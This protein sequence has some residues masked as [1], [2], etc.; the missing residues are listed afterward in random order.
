MAQL[1]PPLVNAPAWHA[2]QLHVHGWSNH[3]AQQQPQSMQHYMAWAAQAGLDAVWWTDHN[4]LFT[5]DRDFRLD[6]EQG[7]VTESLDI[8]LPY[9]TTPPYDQQWYAAW[10]AATYS[11]TIQPAASLH[12][13]WLRMTATADGDDNLGRFQYRLQSYLRTPVS[14]H[15][16]VRPLA[17]D[18]VLEFDARLCGDSGSDAY[19]EVRVDLSWHYNGAP[20]QQAIVYRLAPADHPAEVVSVGNRVTVTV[21][22]TDTHLSL[23]LLPTAALL[24]DGADNA[25]QDL[26]LAV[27]ARRQATA[28]LEVSKVRL[29]SR[30][31][32]AAHNFA[33]YRQTAQLYSDRYSV[34]SFVVWEQNAGRQHF[35]PFLPTDSNLIP[36][37]DDVAGHALVPMIHA[38]GGAVSLNHPFGASYPP[39]LSEAQQEERLRSTS[40]ELLAVRAWGV[41]AIEIYPRR[42]GVDL[43]RHLKLWDLLAAN[44]VPLCGVMSSDQHGGPMDWYQASMVTWIEAPVPEQDL[45]LSGL[46]RCRVFFG[47]L[48]RFD[49]VFDLRLGNAAMGQTAHLPRGHALLQVLIDPLPADAVVKLVHVARQPGPELVYLIDHQ[50]IDVTQPIRI[51]VNRPGFVRVELWSARGEPMAFSNRIMIA[52]IDTSNRLQYLP[53]FLVDVTRP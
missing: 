7:E 27:A 42:A 52:P 24:A 25:V 39:L 22:L 15:A 43:T 38:A 9:P 34:A 2:V 49:G 4:K 28:C 12:G 30:Q 44:D 35:N 32:N 29:F 37:R 53:M 21:P 19:A 8:K 33:A 3:N 11:P 31:P 18:P 50:P 16:L 10:L 6:F 20:V 26:V 40:Q 23:P 46:K 17:S 45:L 1:S 41:D 36:D 47:D 13:N 5:Q 48:R 14:G 51:D